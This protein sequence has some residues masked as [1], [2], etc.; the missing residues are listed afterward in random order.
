[1]TT[2]AKINMQDDEFERV[3]EELDIKASSF[4]IFYFKLIF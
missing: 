4:F 2:F 1:M 3:M